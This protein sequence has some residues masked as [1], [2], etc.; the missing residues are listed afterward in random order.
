MAAA[1]LSESGVALKKAMNRRIKTL[2]VAAAASGV[3]LMIDAEQSW[4]QPA[5]DNEV[6]SL[7]VRRRV[8]CCFTRPFCVFFVVV[9]KGRVTLKRRGRGEKEERKRRGGKRL[10]EAIAGVVALETP[11]SSSTPSPCV[12]C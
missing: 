3:R 10:N 5:I 1:A 12:L 2:A 11:L 6:Y 4:L 8:L 7:Q 9:R